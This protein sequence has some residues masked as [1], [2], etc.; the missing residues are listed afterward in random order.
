MKKKFLHI[1]P[2]IILISFSNC[3]NFGACFYCNLY[4]FNSN[5]QKYYTNE[6]IHINAS[7]E[8]DYNQFNEIAY[9][10]IQIFDSYNN[11]V[12]NSSKYDQIGF[13]EKNWN[14]SIINLNVSFSNSSNTLFIKF[15]SYY[16]QISTMDMVI[17]YLETIEIEIMKRT[18]FCDLIGFKNHLNISENLSITA[19]FYDEFLG[20][21]SFLINKSI[22]FKI[23]SNKSL[24]FQSNY[25]INESGMIK[26]NLIP[27][28]QLK[29]GKNILIFIFKNNI[30]YNDSMFFYEIFLEKIPVF[31]DIIEFKEDLGKNEDLK[32]ILRFYYFLNNSLN[33]LNNHCI[34]VIIF[35]DK[36]L[37]YAKNY[38]TDQFGFLNLSLSQE[39]FLFNVDCKLIVI[40]FF[41]NGTFLLENEKLILT[42]R[43][44]LATKQ[45]SPF[46]YNYLFIVIFISVLLAVLSVGIFNYYKR[47]K[48]KILADITIKY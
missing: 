44:S 38:F 4:Y 2:F 24:I 33:T 21:N 6:S 5:S 1:I 34:R 40:E 9:I 8:L 10:Q 3:T 42:A 22:L 23:I 11:I 7:W 43:V 48:E 32:I 37:T 16:Y 31:V 13:S 28:E 15:L 39:F 20:D 35:N 30:V 29:L 45:N 41:F 14:I 25:I 27:S 47:R 46:Q 26:F 36:S 12:W 17:T 18:L 19:I